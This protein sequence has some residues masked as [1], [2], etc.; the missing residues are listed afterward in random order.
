MFTA[1]DARKLQ[2]S[3]YSEDTKDIL[4]EI[5]EG[6]NSRTLRNKIQR[7]LY[8]YF[9]AETIAKELNTLGYETDIEYIETYPSEYILT[10]EW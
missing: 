10:V 2:A 8:K 4:R 9:D 5:E 3:I 7:T 6:I 1:D